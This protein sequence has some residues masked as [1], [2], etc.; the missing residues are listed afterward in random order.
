[1]IASPSV[2][3]AGAETYWQRQQGP[4]AEQGHRTWLARAISQ[5]QRE[6][7][8]KRLQSSARW[9]HSGG[10]LQ[11]EA[12]G[13]HGCGQ[14]SPCRPWTPSPVFLVDSRMQEKAASLQAPL[15]TRHLPSVTEP[16]APERRIPAASSG[17][18]SRPCCPDLCFPGLGH[19]DQGFPPEC[20][21]LGSSLQQGLDMEKGRA[22]PGK[23]FPHQQC[24]QRGP[25]P[26]RAGGEDF[27]AGASLVPFRA[28]W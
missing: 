6:A 25:A 28:N 15:P 8:G 10:C 19:M 3:E 2:E 17:S 27:P 16:W 4:K 26:I 24:P 22:S 13:Q 23:L 7:V 20:C 5:A 11:G 18:S 14:A 12:F 9:A 21:L 1:M